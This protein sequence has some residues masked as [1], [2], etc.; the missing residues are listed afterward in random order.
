MWPFKAK[1]KATTWTPDWCDV[2]TMLI[3]HKIPAH[4]ILS[5]IISLK[6][7]NIHNVLCIVLMKCACSKIAELKKDAVWNQLHIYEHELNFTKLKHLQPLN[8]RNLVPK[9]EQL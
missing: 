5:Q 3:F 6:A 8:K 1:G 9:L 2:T 4:T 7:K